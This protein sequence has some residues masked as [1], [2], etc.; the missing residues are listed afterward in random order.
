VDD[1][2]AWAH[3]EFSEEVL[4]GDTVEEWVPLSGKQGDE[5]E[6]MINIILSFT[7][8]CYIHNPK[9]SVIQLSCIQKVTNTLSCV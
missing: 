8:S 6:G 3:F 4:N 2:I 7:V 9:S 5:K 1:R